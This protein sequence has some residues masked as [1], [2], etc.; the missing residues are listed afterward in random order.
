M[1]QKVQRVI[2]QKGMHDEIPGW[3]KMKKG[4]KYGEF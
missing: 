4:F 3:F 1:N 2:S